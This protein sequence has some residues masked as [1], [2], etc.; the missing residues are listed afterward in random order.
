[1]S[2]SYSYTPSGLVTA[3][4]ALKAKEEAALKATE[5][6]TGPG[7]TA[8]A[9][10]GDSFVAAGVQFTATG[11]EA[12]DLE[13]YWTL[14]QQMVQTAAEKNGAN[15]ILIPEL[16]LGPYFCQSQEASLLELAVENVEEC[17]IVK[18]MQRLA[19][20][21]NVVLPI[22]LYERTNNSLFNTVVMIDADGTI[23]GKYRKSHIPDGT[24]YQEKFYFSPGDTGFR[25]FDTRVGKVGI[26]ICWDQWFPEPA[27]AMALMGADV[28]LYPTAIGSEPQDPTIQSAD[29]WQ[30]VMQGHSGANVSIN[31]L[32]SMSHCLPYTQQRD[33]LTP[34]IALF[35]LLYFCR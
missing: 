15:L 16:F 11:I 17:F 31:D 10:A 1:M 3:F 7:A 12:S 22:S 24:G 13:G 35:C 14:A 34:D 32:S 9:L 33:P 19:I 23:L 8:P 6:P 27:R 21:Y 28:L 29:H 5:A 20:Q 4:R 25:V 26:A 18:R 2:T 30:R